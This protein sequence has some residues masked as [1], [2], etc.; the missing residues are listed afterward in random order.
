MSQKLS[1]ILF[2]LARFALKEA[3]TPCI[4]EQVMDEHEVEGDLG[5]EEDDEPLLVEEEEDRIPHNVCSTSEHQF[6][7][8]IC[9]ADLALL[10]DVHVIVAVEVV[11]HLVLSALPLHYVFE[12]PL[13]DHISLSTF[14]SIVD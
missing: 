5:E 6:V 9:L 1:I 12:E 11:P 8:E 10:R 3:G 14:V 4:L 7:V 13:L 2:K